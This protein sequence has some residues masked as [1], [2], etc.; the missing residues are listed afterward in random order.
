[1]GD[2]LFTAYMGGFLNLQFFKDGLYLHIQT[3]NDSLGSTVFTDGNT[4]AILANQKA[5]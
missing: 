3:V 5:F 2:C 4:T 1:M